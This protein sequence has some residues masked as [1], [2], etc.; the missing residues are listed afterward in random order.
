MATVT[1]TPLVSATTTTPH[2][3]RPRSTLNGPDLIQ[4]HYATTDD[5]D[6]SGPLLDFSDMVAAVARFQ[7]KFKAYTD[8]AIATINDEKADFDAGRLQH[9]NHL[10]TLDREIEEAKSAQRQLWDTVSQER[11]ADAQ[12]RSRI[13][14]L[15]S[16]RASLSQRSAELQAEI[17]EAKAKL[18]AKKKAKHAQRQRF[19]AQVDQNGPELKLLESRTGCSIQPTKVGDQLRFTFQLVNPDDWSD[20]CFFVV[21]VS[22][23]QYAVSSHRPQLAPAVFEPMLDE[24]NSTRKFYTF[25]KQ[26][27]HALAD[28]TE[29]RRKEAREAARRAAA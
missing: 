21:D 17:S 10:S 12:V 2:R 5:H 1:R 24:L 27:R 22:K 18:E 7:R 20:E 16:Q 19:R 15:T 28:E 14:A 6:G 11:E 4:S 3:L 8:H 23:P 9:A 25:V 26:M 13:Q 29:R